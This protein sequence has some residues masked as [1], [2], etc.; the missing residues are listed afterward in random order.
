[1]RALKG[2][3][4]LE[5]LLI[6]GL[7]LS[8]VVVFFVFAL[9]FSSDNVRSSQAKDAIDKLGKAADYVYALGPNAK[10][11]VRVNLPEGVRFV[12]IS[13]N[14]IWLRVSLQS[15][16]ADFFAT[17]RG[18]VIGSLPD[19]S[20]QQ[21]VKLA[22]DNNGNVLIGNTLITCSPSSVT[23][24]IAQGGS[25]SSSVTIANVG[26]AQITGIAATL[27]GNLGSMAS[28]TPPAATLN[29]GA[30]S[31]VGIS[32]SVPGAQATGTYSGNVLVSGS[33]NAQCSSSVTLFVTRAGGADAT[34][35]TVSGIVTYPASANTT[36]AIT[37]NATG[38]D[39]ATGNSPIAN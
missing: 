30:S 34:G 1:M 6:T 24:S 20:G 29:V 37:V 16:D 13:G 38:S 19:I 12:N 10:E 36:T 14:R 31:P 11:T 27:S 18:T 26:A 39:V 2:Q 23:V 22:V 3:A 33:G 9:N 8:L 5:Q 15:G 25:G 28:L 32:F 35:P 17:T 4:S 7:A 21:D